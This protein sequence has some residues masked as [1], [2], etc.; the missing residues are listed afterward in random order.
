MG[1]G[2][3]NDSV[4][5]RRSYSDFDRDGNGRVDLQAGGADI[6]LSGL[7]GMM[8]I[9][10][11]FCNIYS[12][13]SARSKLGL[14]S[15]STQNANAVAITGGS[16]TGITDLAVADGGTGASNAAGARTNLGLV[17]GTDVLA[18]DAGLQNLAG[19]AMAANKFYYT[20]ADNVHVAG[21]ITAAARSILDDA[22]VGAIR[23]TLGMGIGDSPTVTGLNIS[24]SVDWVGGN[25]I[26]VPLAGDIQ[27]YVDAA[28]AGDTLV[29]ASGVYTITSTITVNKQLN[30]V[31][32]GSSGFVT[33]PVTPSHGTLIESSTAAVTGFAITN[34][35]VRISDLSVNLTGAG[36]TAMSV[37]PNLQGIALRNIDVIV[38]S[39]GANAGFSIHESDVVMRDL[40][41]YIT[42][43]DSTAV[44]VLF[45]N[46]NT[47][48]KNATIDCFSVTG[49]VVGG[50]TYAHGFSAYNINDAH[51][52]VMNF[53]N[54]V[55]R[56]L[57]G[58]GADI[59]V[60]ADSAVTSNVTVNAYLCT[61]NGLTYDAK[62]TNS[63]V[64]NIG[65]SV[66]E[67]NLTLGTITYRAAMTSAIITDG[68][69]TLTGGALTGL[70]TPLT[71][72]DG[73]TGASNAA[74]ART[75]LGLVIGSDVQAYNANLTTMAALSSA[76][77][78]FIVGSAAGWVAESGA[79]ARTSIG[80]GPAN[81]PQFTG[82]TLTGDLTVPDAGKITLGSGKATIQF[83]DE[84][85]D[86]ITISN[87]RVG[88]GVTPTAAFNIDTSGGAITDGLR[89][90][91]TTERY[92]S[93]YSSGINWYLEA[94]GG[95]SNDNIYIRPSTTSGSVYLGLG[96]GFQFGVS[97]APYLTITNKTHENGDGGR[98]SR[99]IARGEQDEGEESVL[100]YIEFAHHGSGDDQK[101]LWRV[102][103]NDGDD[104]AAP[105][106]T[107]I[108]IISDGGVFLNSLKSGADQG[109]AGAATGELWIDTDDQ[110]IKVGA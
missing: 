68:V 71:V 66:L 43:S 13:A 54:S 64:L 5:N 65:G 110:T 53:S 62:Q 26:W 88:I 45:Y 67:N 102:L 50:A 28:V 36:S 104:D 29:L 6:D 81:S 38:N 76:D 7:L 41:F 55:V 12:G 109:A 78:N 8:Y 92:L 17:I 83:D 58:T 98:E 89:L 57:G 23:T 25:V 101:G 16:I 37:G 103:V 22:S 21:D 32:R 47:A 108:T 73:G 72:A 34:D 52:L 10:G 2:D 105:S 18:Y 63:N 9:E 42:S 30:I 44:G 95:G 14:G 48:T 79:T 93:L 20:S 59:A 106:K 86:T 4:I 80:L 94:H 31:G 19:V 49:T 82:L 56:A 99:I 3:S 69:A 60:I 97:T 35:N 39:S 77:G 24:S 74:G 15:I 87:S 61:L 107:G 90:T 75:N 33:T 11:G 85:V 91:R 40:T 46:N 1:F 96:D 100:G 84:T 51:T 70:T 27:T